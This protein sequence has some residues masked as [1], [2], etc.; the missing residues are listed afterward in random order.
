MKDASSLSQ[1]TSLSHG[2]KGERANWSLDTV[3][4]NNVKDYPSVN[5][6]K[7]TGLGNMK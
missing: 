5:D 4:D 2:Q 3:V 6:G 7:S 1:W